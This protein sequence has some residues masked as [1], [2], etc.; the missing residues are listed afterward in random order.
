MVHLIFDIYLENEFWFA[1][2]QLIF[3]MLGMGAS[4]TIKDFGEIA[5]EPRAFSVGTAIQVLMVPVVTL[6]YLQFFG[7]NP[8]ALS[9][10]VAVGLA[11]CAAIPGGAVSN[12]FTLFAGGN[13][14]LSI[15]ITSVTTV[16]CLVTTPI[17]LNALII[18]HMPVNFTMPAG[19]IALDIFLCM[20]L[21]LVVG[22]MYLKW[23][24][25]TAARVSTFF[26]RAS[27]AVILLIVIG[28]FGAGRLDLTSFGLTNVLLVLLFI[29]I[30]TAVGWLVPR[31]IGLSQ[32]DTTAIGME[33]TVR[34]TNL[35]LLIKA[36]IFPAIVGQPDPMGDAV[37]FTLLL[38]GGLMLL[39]SALLIKIVRPQQSPALAQS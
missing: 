27:L 5:K 20:L 24:P 9:V 31:L 3:A 2:A 16:A 35:G 6:A 39:I 8:G 10:G 32:K 23:F 30:L 4:L 28:S 12:I 14:A 26:I 29:S 34:S 11:L 22:M 38:Y 25:S 19:K 18:E 15:A 1:A 37:L 7:M 33:V 21:P 36:S 17:I 13:I